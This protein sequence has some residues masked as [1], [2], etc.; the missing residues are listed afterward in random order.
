[1]LASYVW[2]PH[3]LY[4]INT[5][6]KVQRRAA[7]WVTSEYNP[8]SSVTYLLDQLNWKSLQSRRCVER[9][10]LLYKVLYHNLPSI[11]LSEYFKPPS[12]TYIIPPTRTHAYQQSYFPRTMK[13]WNNLPNYIIEAKTLELFDNCILS[14]D[15]TFF[16][17]CFEAPRCNQH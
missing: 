4:L 9:L 14:L 15:L 8:V 13:L 2:D 5:L 16:L 7:R 10:N 12:S 11:H 17:F 3:Q 6:E 1:M